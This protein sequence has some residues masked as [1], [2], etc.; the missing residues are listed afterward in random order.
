[1][2]DIDI[3]WEDYVFKDCGIGVGVCF[4]WKECVKGRL[5]VVYVKMGLYGFD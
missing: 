4:G 3:V 1:M 2:G 5:I